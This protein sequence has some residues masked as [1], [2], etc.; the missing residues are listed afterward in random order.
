MSAGRIVPLWRW[1]LTLASLLAGLPAVAAPPVATATCPPT[2]QAPSPD[3]V[4]QGMREASN[5][6]F[7][8]RIERDGHSSWL[9]GT[10]HAA[11]PAW[12]YPGPGVIAAL[13]HSDEVALEL[14]VLDPDIASRLQAGLRV[15]AGAP[16]LPEALSRRIAA[17]TAA[18]CLGDALKGLSPVMQVITLGVLSGRRDGIDPAWGIDGFLAGL[19]RGLQLPVR[20]LETPEAQLALLTGGSP[21]D[22][23]ALI[24][25]TLEDL[26]RGDAQRVLLRLA[27]AWS[28][29]RL[30]E[31]STYAQWCNCLN[32]PA[33]R[34]LHARLL[35]QRN[36][37]LAASVAARHQAGKRVFAAVGA[38]HMV[39]PQGLPALLAAQGFTVERV[40]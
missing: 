21:A 2:A 15:P 33:E 24:S 5:H 3:Q 34:A 11:R 6:G 35:D 18:A 20:S 19:A 39:G 38:L 26:E 12:M 37:G 40:Y 22:T 28:E 23:E 36:G 13:R 7:L 25:T 14:D 31:L 29:R 8:W 9:Y 32:T 27:L 17:Q 10:I 16:P 30:D 4:Q 1:V